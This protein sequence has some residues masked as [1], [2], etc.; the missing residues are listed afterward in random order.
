VRFKGLRARLTYANVMSTLALLV[1]LTGGAT[2]IAL[3]LPKNSV[4]SKQIAPGA[5]KKSD[6]AK[7]AV[8][9]NKV[10][11]SSLGKVPTATRADSAA[12]AD[13]ATTATSLAGFGPGNLPKTQSTSSSFFTSSLE[14]KI[15][16]FGTFYLRCETNEGVDDT[17][18]E[19]TFGYLVSIP[20]AI[21]GGFSS[22]AGFPFDTP[23]NRVIAD[24]E[25]Q[26]FA[27]FTNQ[28]DRVYYAYRLAIPGTTKV[29]MI[30]ASG[31]DNESNSG[32]AGQ[33]QAFVI[34]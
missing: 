17:D 23:V 33:M 27:T 26:G 1:A 10:K 31:F 9:G 28:D 8:T 20:S 13:Q 19:A 32:C 16:G 7:D 21:S 25:P 29:A 18:D 12:T 34:S 5:V 11:E 2:A 24:D 4:K 22:S 6:I 3:S 30:E 15:T 14:M